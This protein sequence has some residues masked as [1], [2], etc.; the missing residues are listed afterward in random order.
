ML[1]TEPEL[2][3]GL[4]W[5]GEASPS[6][7]AL[8]PKKGACFL[9]ARSDRSAH[10]G[11]PRQAAAVVTRFLAAGRP[12][13]ALAGEVRDDVGHIGLGLSWFRGDVLFRSFRV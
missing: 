6:A 1:R 10:D 12:V 4:R 9:A 8:K 7:T 3:E 13:V 11:L 2:L 5:R